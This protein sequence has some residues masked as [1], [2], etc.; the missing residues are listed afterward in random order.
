MTRRPTIAAI[1]AAVAIRLEVPQRIMTSR[2]QERASTLPRQIAMALAY[3]LTDHSN[4]VVGQHFGG[5]DPSTVTYARQT[6]AR[7]S[8]FDS[9]LDRKIS[10]IRAALIDRV[11]TP[12]KPVQLAFLD[13]PLFDLAALPA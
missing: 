5:R 4:A 6:L 9:E 1:K 8:R 2:H 3:E 13:G 12:R 10:R 7:R 11:D